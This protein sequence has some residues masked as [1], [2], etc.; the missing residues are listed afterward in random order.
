M[1][2][3]DNQY[4]AI[5]KFCKKASKKKKRRGGLYK[6]FNSYIWGKVPDD[7]EVRRMAALD[8]V[9]Y[10]TLSEED[11]KRKYDQ[12]P[13]LQPVNPIR[14]TSFNQQL[15]NLLANKVIILLQL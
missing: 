11:R 5:L 7:D 2:G 10:D 4:E 1:K 13:L 12:F 9:D 8:G 3:Y 15:R 14:F 6:S